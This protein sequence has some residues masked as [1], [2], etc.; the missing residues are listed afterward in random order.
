MRA[1]ATARNVFATVTGGT[2]SAEAPGKTGETLSPVPPGMTKENAARAPSVLEGNRS[3]RDR[4]GNL[5][6]G[7]KRGVP[8]K[9][10]RLRK[11]KIAG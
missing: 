3:E 11:M 7:N 4:A 1:A 10:P 6:S 9:S 8:Q 5:S 2:L